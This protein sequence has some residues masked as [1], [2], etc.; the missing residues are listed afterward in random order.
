MPGARCGRRST[1]TGY[2]GEAGWE[3]PPAATG[4]SLARA[5]PGSACS[6]RAGEDTE[7][8]AAY[9][10]ESD[11]F[12]CLWKTLRRPARWRP[13]PWGVRTAAGPRRCFPT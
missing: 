6:G 9:M 12:V 11:P 4:A 1:T 5:A 8:D 3:P 7:D 13:A 10:G 2:G